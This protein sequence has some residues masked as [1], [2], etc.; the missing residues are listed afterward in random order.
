MQVRDVMQRHVTIVHEDEPL[1]L[2][3]QLMHWLEIRHLPVLRRGDERVVGLLS[4]RDLLRAVAAGAAA[5]GLQR[6]VR[7]FM[8]SPVEH[9]HPNAPL[10]DAAADFNTKKLGCLPVID[11]GELV[12]ILAVGD[13]LSVLAQYPADH[14]A[15]K[16]PQNV[17]PIAS[18]M[19]PEPVAVHANDML[20]PT[21]VRLAT[22]GVRHACVVD[23]TGVV[24]GMLSDRDVR[25]ALGDPKH[26]VGSEHMPARLRNL[27]VA[28][29][30]TPNPCT[31]EQDA[32]IS[33]ALSLLLTRRVGALPVVD[34]NGRLRG[35]VSYV[36]ML[37]QLSLSDTST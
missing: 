17:R 16:V 5:E 32:S 23:E 11:A 13:V 26:I 30:M 37:K 3:Q 6:P 7:D 19:Y 31:I 28:Q 15:P 20:M 8:V 22:L 10:A 14:R 12:G 34:G 29:V 18:I 36:D 21:A 35:I 9:I 4:E 27:R 33:T 1:A 24:T 2:A 25:R